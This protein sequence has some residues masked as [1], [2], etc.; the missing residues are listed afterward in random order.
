MYAITF[1]FEKQLLIYIQILIT[2]QRYKMTMG[3]QKSP[4]LVRI[5]QFITEG[6]TIGLL[7]HVL[8]NRI[9][10]KFFLTF[11]GISFLVIGVS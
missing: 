10:T 3:I 8:P 1:G 9:T 2:Q 4:T 6:I 5:I 11:L 7:G